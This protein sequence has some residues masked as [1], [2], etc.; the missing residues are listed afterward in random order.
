VATHFQQTMSAATLLQDDGV[1][2][3]VLLGCLQDT[4]HV[5]LPLQLVSKKFCGVWNLHRVHVLEWRVAFLED[6]ACG[7]QDKLDDFNSGCSC[8]YAM[9]YH[10]C[11]S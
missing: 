8:G 2:A 6:R 11:R 7:L 4:T 9:G 10:F 1:L 3:P 5:W